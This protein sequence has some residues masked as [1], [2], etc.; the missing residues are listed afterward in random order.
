MATAN[1][2]TSS[3]T[4]DAISEDLLETLIQYVEPIF[5][6]RVHSSSILSPG[7]IGNQVAGQK[8]IANLKA[9]IL[10]VTSAQSTGQSGT[11]D[12]NVERNLQGVSL[13]NNAIYVFR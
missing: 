7:N 4:L 5:Y 2:C 6:D 10:S 13:I 12:E 8:F 3:A 1:A 9:L 11:G